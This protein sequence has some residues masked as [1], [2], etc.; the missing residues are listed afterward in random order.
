[1]GGELMTLTGRDQSQKGEYIQPSSKKFIF[2][3]KFN[4]NY[5]GIPEGVLGNGLGEHSVL[6]LKPITWEIL[7]LCGKYFNEN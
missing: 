1:M 3:R 2:R 7:L 6:D 5:E 4:D